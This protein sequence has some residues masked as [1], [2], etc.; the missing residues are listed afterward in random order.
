MSRRTPRFEQLQE[1]VQLAAFT[2]L[3]EEK[4]DTTI[5]NLREF[6]DSGENVIHLIDILVPGE[7]VAKPRMIGQGN[8]LKRQQRE[9][10]LTVAFRRG[11]L[12]E[13]HRQRWSAAAMDM[14]VPK[15]NQ[16]LDLLQAIVNKAGIQMLSYVSTGES[17]VSTSSMKWQEAQEAKQLQTQL[18]DNLKHFE[19]AINTHQR[20]LTELKQLLNESVENPSIENMHKIIESFARRS[21]ENAIL[22]LYRTIVR[23]DARLNELSRDSGRESS[24]P[25]DP[26]LLLGEIATTKAQLQAGFEEYETPFQKTVSDLKKDVNELQNL[27][28]PSTDDCNEID[29]VTNLKNGA[30]RTERLI[31]QCRHELRVMQTTSKFS[32]DNSQINLDDLEDELDNLRKQLLAEADRQYELNELQ[33][34]YEEQCLIVDQ[35]TN[36]LDSKLVSYPKTDNCEC[37]KEYQLLISNA[38]NELLS[39]IENARNAWE[40]LETGLKG[41]TIHGI[42]SNHQISMLNDKVAD[43][44]RRVQECLTDLDGEIVRLQNEEIDRFRARIDEFETR[45]KN[46]APAIDSNPAAINSAVTKLNELNDQFA[47]LESQICELG[48]VGKHYQNQFHE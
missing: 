2:R 10:A 5:G 26:T 37:V 1:T 28:N 38:R 47:I 20:R 43:L 36:Q 11:I 25:I 46:S 21:D 24:N 41:K 17:P 14:T 4:L 16:L 6:C 3:F 7:S 13:E 23:D 32:Q 42:A 31:D 12:K 45:V 9:Y 29:Q 44:D 30:D 18:I 35:T 27:L 40:Q 8:I 33:K 39:V 48:A 15:A 22:T 34:H 19:I